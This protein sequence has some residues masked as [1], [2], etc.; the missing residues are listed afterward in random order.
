MAI[1]LPNKLFGS[2]RAS[3]VELAVHFLWQTEEIRELWKNS[4]AWKG[5]QSQKFTAFT[6]TF[7]KNASGKRLTFTVTN[8]YALV[9]KSPNLGAYL[10][11]RLTFAQHT[12]FEWEVQATKRGDMD[13]SQPTRHQLPS[14][15]ITERF[16]LNLFTWIPSFET[17]PVSQPIR[18]TVSQCRWTL[19]STRS[20]KI[21]P[22]LLWT[23]LQLLPETSRSEKHTGYLM[24]IQEFS[25]K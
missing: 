9:S 16:H 12:G 1:C 5:K 3:S 17:A 7:T 2:G 18:S 8:W 25:N 21:S 4:P 19:L 13:I 14:T 24:L 10:L 23:S 22:F 11:S 15:F 6:S 20:C